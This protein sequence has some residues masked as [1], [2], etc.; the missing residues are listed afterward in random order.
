MRKTCWVLLLAVMLLFPLSCGHPTTMVSLTVSPAATGVVGVGGG[1]QVQFTATG[2]F[3]HPI[4]TRD[5]TNQVAW[6]SAIHDVVTVN[7]QGVATSGVV[8]GVSTITATAGE[9]LI[10]QVGPGAIVTGTASF[11]V[12]NPN[13]P[14]CP[15][16]VQ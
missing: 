16:T 8:C 13:N 4:E 2:Q 10:G 9:P 12:A 14:S 11:T 3:V 6:S 5:V 7:Q 15:Q 1:G